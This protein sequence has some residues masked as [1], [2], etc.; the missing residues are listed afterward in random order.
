MLRNR[1]FKGTKG[2][3]AEVFVSGAVALSTAA[4]L[5]AFVTSAA[6]GAIGI[7]NALTNANV[8]TTALAEGTKIF[9]AQKTVAGAGN[10]RIHKSA[11]FEFQKAGTRYTPYSAPVKQVATVTF[12]SY[13]PVVGD[14]LGVKVIGTTQGVE[15]FPTKTYWHQVV[16]ADTPT[17]IVASLLAQINSKKGV[18]FDGDAQVVATAA[19]G[20]LTLTAIEFGLSFK[21]ALPGDTYAAATVNYTTPINIGSGDPDTVLAF[22]KEGQIYDGVTTNYPGGNFVPDDFG[23]TPLFTAPALTYHCYNFFPWKN[24]FSPTPV[25]K[26]HHQYNLVLYVPASGTTPNAT[27]QTIFGFTPAP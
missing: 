5:D 1:Y 12:T 4:T 17:T 19:A 20:V 25:N 13:T 22:E 18:N 6:A 16:A 27:L 8:G 3:N 7:F 26:H 15:P 21:V 2:F 14:N 10:V 24:E 9:I 11:E 23:T